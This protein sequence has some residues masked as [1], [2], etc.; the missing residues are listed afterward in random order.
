MQGVLTGQQQGQQGLAAGAQGGCPTPSPLHHFIKAVLHTAVLRRQAHTPG[1][2]GR[3]DCFPDALRAGYG[4][5][6]TQGHPLLTAEG[7]RKSKGV[8]PRLGWR[9]SALLPQHTATACGQWRG[10]TP[11]PPMNGAVGGGRTSDMNFLQIGRISCE[12][13]ALNIMTCFSCGVALKISCT[14]ARMSA[15]R[16]TCLLAA[17]FAHFRSK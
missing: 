12:S 14:S 4:A 17:C 16:R 2:Q 11:Q 10:T 7:W 13:V 9:H 8:Q 6:T 1:R 15:R 3:L 5:R